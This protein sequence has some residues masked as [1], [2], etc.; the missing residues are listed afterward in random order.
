L[1]DY[2]NVNSLEVFYN[3]LAEYLRSELHERLQKFRGRLRILCRVKPLGMDDKNTVNYPEAL[4][5]SI[6]EP[7]RAI[8]ITQDGA[9]KNLFYFDRVFDASSSQQIVLYFA[10][11]TNNSRFLRK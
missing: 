9:K 1:K 5:S 3:D 7:L 8:E 6:H 10:I 2:K 11:K 4:N